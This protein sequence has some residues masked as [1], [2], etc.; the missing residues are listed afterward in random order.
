[1]IPLASDLLPFPGQMRREDHLKSVSLPDQL[2]SS[3]RITILCSSSRKCP[4]VTAV[5]VDKIASRC[6]RV[7]HDAPGLGNKPAQARRGLADRGG[8]DRLDFDADRLRA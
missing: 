1:M 2:S 5:P 7:T 6:R 8:R 4:E 3:R